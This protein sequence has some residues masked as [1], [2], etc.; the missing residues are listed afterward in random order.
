MIQILFFAHIR[1]KTGT[2]SI[3]LEYSG[4]QTVADVIKH[5]I[6]RDEDLNLL[7]SQ[8][9]LVAVNQTLSEPNAQVND[10]DELAFFPPVTGG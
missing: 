8:D 6:E 3:N 7:T 4:E 10:G 9:V 5:L 2:S 1:E